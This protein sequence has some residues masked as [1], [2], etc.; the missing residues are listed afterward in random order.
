MLMPSCRWKPQIGAIQIQRV[1]FGE[2]PAH[3]GVR[4]LSS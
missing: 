4:A 2:A 3:V 1:V